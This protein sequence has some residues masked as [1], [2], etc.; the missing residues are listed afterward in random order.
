MAAGVGRISGSEFGM[1]GESGNNYENRE[2]EQPIRISVW[3]S[4]LGIKL[5]GWAQPVVVR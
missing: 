5:I 1:F 2:G 4:L 3:S